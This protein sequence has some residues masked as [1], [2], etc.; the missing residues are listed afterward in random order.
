[1]G[2]TPGKSKGGFDLDDSDEERN[3]DTKKQLLNESDFELNEKRQNIPTPSQN[4][5][6]QQADDLFG[7]L[8]TDNSLGAMETIDAFVGPVKTEFDDLK[9]KIDLKDKELQDLETD[10]YKR[11]SSKAVEL[12]GIGPEQEAEIERHRHLFEMQ[13]LMELNQRMEKIERE[14]IEL[15]KAE[16]RVTARL[17]YRS[18]VIGE[19][20]TELEAMHE[21][22]SRKREL[23]LTKLYARLNGKIREQIAYH[24]GNL[25]VIQRKRVP[26]AETK[27]EMLFDGIRDQKLKANWV[28]TPQPV[29]I[30]LMTARCM[31]DK[32]P[33]GDYVIRAGVMDRLVE[34]KLYYKFIEY[35]E[36]VKEQRMVDKEKEKMGQNQDLANLSVLLSQHDDEGDDSSNI[37]DESHYKSVMNKPLFNTDEDEE[38][39]EDDDNDD[40][41]KG[42]TW[43]QDVADH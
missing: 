10:F 7:A 25:K 34:N 38:G 28:K 42:V 36:R 43:G 41:R 29:V 24:E 35:G 11:V 5:K 16:Q 32:V 14:K 3:Y 27:N 33:K 21:S 1:M 37:D 6:G 8:E 26:Y 23:T 13:Q 4:R 15:L 30:K 40:K 12:E 31:R 20:L 9:R 17:S 2:Q 39:D 18:K 22:E 19:R